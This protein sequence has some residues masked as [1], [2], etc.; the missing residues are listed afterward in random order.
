MT[1]EDFTA[2]VAL[3]S[4][5]RANNKQKERKMGIEWVPIVMFIGIAA[6][7]IG[8]L[9]FGNKTK[10]AKQ[11]TVQAAIER[12]D[13]LTPELIAAISSEPSA[14]AADYRRGIILIALGVGISVFGYFA[15]PGETELIGIAS[16]PVMLGLG[17]LFV[18]KFGP[19]D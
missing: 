7:L 1:E 16:I 14:P 6:V 11:V 2:K 18:F 10:Q 5:T 4:V 19:K 15:N 17:Y 9:Y 8:Y 3:D 12:G 13:V